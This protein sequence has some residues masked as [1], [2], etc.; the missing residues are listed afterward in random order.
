M[1]AR[2]SYERALA[3]D[4]S[5]GNAAKKSGWGRSFPL[6][7]AASHRVPLERAAIL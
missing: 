2:A 1:F 6:R 3:A 5:R 4:P 7:G